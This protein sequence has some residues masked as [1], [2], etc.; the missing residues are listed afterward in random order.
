[1][2]RREIPAV[3]I[4]PMSDRMA[5]F[6]GRDVADVQRACFLR[7]L[8]ARG[9]RFR[10]PSSGLS[11]RPGTVVLFQYQARIIASAVFVR[12]EKFERPVGGCA[13]ELHF[14]P[15][16]FRT[17]DPLDVGAM[18]AIWPRFR[19][20]GH[21]KQHLNPMR[22]GAFVRRLKSLASPGRRSG[23]SQRGE[24]HPR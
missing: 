9:G 1:M 18:R 24:P 16:S 4:W 13:G 8:P 20:F 15:D 19:G 10:Y 23:E 17:F 3:R 2:R 7:D 22:Y 5:G 14:E 21:V 6:R 12:D 11:A